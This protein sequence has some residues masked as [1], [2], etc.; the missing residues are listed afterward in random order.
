[1]SDASTNAPRQNAAQKPLP[2]WITSGVLGL[3]LGGGACFAAMYYHYAPVPATNYQGP[4]GGD[5]AAG[6]SPPGGA[7]GAPTAGGGGGMPGGM[8]GGGM[9]GGGM[10]GGMMGGGGMGGGGGGGG[11][12]GKRNLTSIVGKLDL[13]SKGIS[14]RLDEEQSAKLAEQL[15]KLEEGEKMTQEE[16]QERADAIEALLTDEQKETLA[17]FEV[18]RGSGGGGGGGG[19]STGGPA[20]GGGGAP[21]VPGMGGNPSSSE[22]DDNPFQQETN[23]SRLHSL[24]DRLNSAA[25]EKGLETS[26]TKE[27]GDQ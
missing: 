1:M 4:Y 7:G 23:Q 10:G 12:R 13:A 26:E 15:A 24:R 9:M 27:A 21:R 20:G 11:A 18:P 3:A 2:P 25:P 14:F 8:M 22:D 19:G 17:Q 5:A 16:A 6:G